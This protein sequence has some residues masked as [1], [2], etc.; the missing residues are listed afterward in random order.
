M[1]AGS[2]ALLSEAYST[3]LDLAKNLLLTVTHRFT[4]GSSTASS[5]SRLPYHVAGNG[6]VESFVYS[7]KER[8]MKEQEGRN[9]DRPSAMLKCTSM[10]GTACCY[11]NL[12]GIEAAP[13]RILPQTLHAAYLVRRECRICMLR[14]P[15]KAVDVGCTFDNNQ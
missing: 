9:N 5:A 10:I 8:M 3:S 11:R 15:P 13:Q 12:R 14:I 7:F 6:T 1:F 2:Y 4:E